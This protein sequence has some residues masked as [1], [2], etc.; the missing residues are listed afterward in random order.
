VT[1]KKPSG[2]ARPSQSGR[3]R[4]PS[5]PPKISPAEIQRRKDAQDIEFRLNRID[6]TMRLMQ[7]QYRA[8]FRAVSAQI[9]V[10]ELSLEEE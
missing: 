6:F 5:R 3:G 8:F 7:D 2:G 4:K 10:L 9:P 1:K